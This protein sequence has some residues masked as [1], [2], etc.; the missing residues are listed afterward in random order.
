MPNAA[1]QDIFDPIS[2]RL[3][4]ENNA[5]A[6][7]Q[8][9]YVYLNGIPIALVSGFSSIDYVLSDQLG[10]PQKLVD[11]FST[12]V[13]DRVSDAFG[14]TAAQAK[15]LS[16]AISLRFPGQEFDANTGLHDN[17]QRDYDPTLG[18]YIQPDPIGLRGGL[19]SEAQFCRQRRQPANAPEK[20]RD[21]ARDRLQRRRPGQ[22]A[23]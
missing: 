5:G 17:D 1:T 19:N 23:D 6:Q 8:R 11:G 3:L 21:A 16:T 9:T 12:L 4:V 2:G 10:Q 13:W 22:L 7:P 14:A 15:G 20:R 18:R